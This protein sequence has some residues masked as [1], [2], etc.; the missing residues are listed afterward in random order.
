[1]EFK[2]LIVRLQEKNSRDVGMSSVK[3]FSNNIGEITVCNFQALIK[4]IE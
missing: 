4:V 2:T 3:F 1:M